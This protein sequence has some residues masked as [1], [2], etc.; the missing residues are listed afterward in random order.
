MIEQ[1]IYN[2]MEWL[3]DLEKDKV[4]LAGF[5]NLDFNIV[6]VTATDMKNHLLYK[7]SQYE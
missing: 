5:P 1:S 6:H 4:E 7:I 3:N 2:F